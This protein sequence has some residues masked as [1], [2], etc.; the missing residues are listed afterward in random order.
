MISENNLFFTND[1]LF[2]SE[3]TGGARL[4]SFCKFCIKCFFSIVF[5]LQAVVCRDKDFFGLVIVALAGV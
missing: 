3:Q 1:F 4:R 5:F 2:T